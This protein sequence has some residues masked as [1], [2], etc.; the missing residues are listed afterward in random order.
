MANVHVSTRTAIGV[1]AILL[2]GLAACDSN[3][4]EP[5]RPDE[6]AASCVEEYTASNLLRR[7]FAFDG[8]VTAVRDEV[9]QRLPPG[10]MPGE[11][12]VP[13]AEFEVHRWFRPDGKRNTALVWMQRDVHVGDR[14]LVA[15][16]PRWGGDPLDNALAWECGFTTTYS[17]SIAQEWIAA[18]SAGTLPASSDASTTTTVLVPPTV[19]P[20]SWTVVPVGPLSPRS[21]AVAVWT[22]TEVIVGGEPRAWC[23]PGGDCSVPDLAPLA[24]G[25]VATDTWHQLPAPGDD[26]YQIT[27]LGSTVVAYSS[28]DDVTTET[29]QPLPPDPL[30]P[31]FGRALVEV[32]GDLYLFALDLV[33]N[34]GSE[35][36]SLLRAARF[37]ATEMHGS[38]DLTQRFSAE[39]PWP[40]ATPSLSELRQC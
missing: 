30:S 17:E 32:D 34:P 4:A 29:R 8:S 14:L 5:G 25:D 22:G 36:P 18:F 40:S 26:W 24:D 15:G 6:E 27:A 19:A 13:R 11:N 38:C 1:V 23:P 16:E 3:A 28:S 39:P 2:P 12:V 35:E 31:S 21:S 33:A 10:D 7:A 37:D 20:D 9:D